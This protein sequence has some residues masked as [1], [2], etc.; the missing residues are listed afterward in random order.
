MHAR[1]RFIP[2]EFDDY[3]ATPKDNLYRS[4]HTA[5]I[6]PQ[7]RAVEVQIRTREMHQHAELGVAAHWRY[8]EGSARDAGYERKIE[9]V[10]E[11]L[12]PAE[13]G[14]RERDR[15]F[16]DRVRSELFED[17][18]Y[19]LTPKGE[20][21]DLP[22]GATPLDFAY[23]L[24]TSLGHRCRGAQGQRPHRAA[25]L[26]ARQRR[27][28]RDP[29]RQA[30]SAEPRLAL[31]QT[32]AI[33]ASA[34]SRAKV[35]AW[36]RQAGCGARTAGQAGRAMVER[37]LARLGAG[38]ALMSTLVGELKAH[39][40]SELYRWLGEGEVSLAQF[41]QASAQRLQRAQRWSAIERAPADALT[42]RRGT[43]RAGAREAAGRHR[44]RRRSAGDARALL[45]PVRP[46]PIVGYVTLGRGVT[47][48]AAGCAGFRR[49]Q[50]RQPERVLPAG[51]VG[52]RRTALP[53]RH[54]D[55]GLRPPGP[56]AR[57][58]GRDRRAA[59]I[60][61]E[62]MNT[63]TDRRTARGPDHRLRVDLDADRPPAARASGAAERDQRRGARLRP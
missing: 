15:D 13:A 6:G 38:P 9:W 45:R 8:K 60:G 58:D 25:D 52:G 29:H 18:V 16:I 41:T 2:G 28:R 48:H 34:R 53:G 14:D 11:L 63:L 12:A 10:R 33:L 31:E 46:Q 4:I 21:V 30:G 54:A 20:V 55:A 26:P 5:V 43:A 32:R 40:A 62:R 51:L 49:M 39:D 59:K 47:V 22:R 35:R 57:H 3:I 7:G 1:W 24:H 27:S 17:R 37:E 36:F 44:G 23:H 42:A 61:I 19:V 50:A 56:G